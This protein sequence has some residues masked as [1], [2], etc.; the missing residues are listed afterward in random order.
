MGRWRIS[1]VG[2]TSEIQGDDQTC[3]HGVSPPLKYAGFAHSSGPT[4]HLIEF[5]GRDLRQVPDR[6]RE[7]AP[8]GAALCSSLKA[9]MPLKGRTPF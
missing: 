5:L 9:G 3:F 1:N 2:P 7:Q 6:Q 4:L 8:V